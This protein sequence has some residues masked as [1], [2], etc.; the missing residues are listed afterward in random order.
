[1][2]VHRSYFGAGAT[3][4]NA[5]T[6]ELDLFVLRNVSLLVEKA[7]ACD[8][9]KGSRCRRQRALPNAVRTVPCY[10]EFLGPRLLLGSLKVW[11]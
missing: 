9:G 5:V 10:L 7:L 2:R 11:D 8:R 1:M 6:P 3:L 4:A